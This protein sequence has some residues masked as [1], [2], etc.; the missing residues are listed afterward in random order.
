[1]HTPRGAF[2]ISTVTVD[3][4]WELRV[5]EGERNVICAARL[6]S[7]KP[8]NAPI[9]VRTISA[10]AEQRKLPILAGLNSPSDATSLG[11]L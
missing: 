6:S 9:S 11:S 4:G 1:V 10:M 8:S 3:E 5:F 2:W 7:M